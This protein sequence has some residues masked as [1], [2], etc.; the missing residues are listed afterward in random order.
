MA[1]EYQHQSTRDYVA[2]KQRGDTVTTARIVAEVKARFETR[3]T[4]GSEIAEL[5]RASM[6]VT[7][8]QPQ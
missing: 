1:D 6:E 8:G 2:A 5:G 4:D 3:T 7:L